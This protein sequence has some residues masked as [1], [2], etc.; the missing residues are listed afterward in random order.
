M[1][2]AYHELSFI[3]L[4]NRKGEDI[5]QVAYVESDDFS[6]RYF[7]PSQECPT[8]LIQ[9]STLCDYTESTILHEW[10]HHEQVSGFGVLPD[11]YRPF[12]WDNY[13]DDIRDYFSFHWWEYDALRFE[14]KHAP[15]EMAE[16]WL[17][18][19]QKEKRGFFA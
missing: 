3:P 1:I 17:I 4:S 7:H 10:R 16:G 12:T 14:L 15:S 11:T 2:S 18:H 9:I 5:P 6:G 19:L 8:G 13:W